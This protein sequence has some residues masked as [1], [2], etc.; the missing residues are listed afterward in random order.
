[1]KNI[2]LLLI[3]NDPE[4]SGRIKALL[5]G[6]RHAPVKIAQAEDLAAALR[7]LDEN[8]ADIILTD[9]DLPDC[10]GLNVVDR[11][12]DKATDLPIIVL[13]GPSEEELMLEAVKSGAQDYLVKGRIDEDRLVRSILY[14]LERSSLIREL[15]EISI[16]DGLTGLYNKRGF[17][18]LAQKYLGLAARFDNI[19]WL[20]YIEMDNL[21]SISERLGAEEGDNALQDMADIL[22][23]TFRESDVIARIGDGA[24]AVIAVNEVEANSK[25]MLARVR[26]NVEI[27]NAENERPYKLSTGVVLVSHSEVAG[28][29]I[30][31][32]LY[33]ANKYMF[34][35]KSRKKK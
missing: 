28:H 8:G 2:S 12:R 19:L 29:N 1:M 30:N 33:T 22:R 35:E 16:S 11:L 34:E 20:V 27:F 3:E 25:H 6:S 9:L 26:E 4:E 24:F 18:A 17:L 7:R 23:R 14:L 32:L 13:A 15:E 10:R 31:K 21:E 5:A